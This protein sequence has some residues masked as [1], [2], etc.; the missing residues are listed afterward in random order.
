MLAAL[1]GFLLVRAPIVFN[2]Y[3]YADDFA[4]RWWAHTSALTPEYVFRSYYGHIQPFGLI[5]GWFM[6]SMFP[7]SF[8]ALMVCTLLAQL[9]TLALLWRIVLRLTG[10]NMAAF[11]AFLVPAFSMFGFETGIWWVEIAETVPYAFFLLVSVWALIRALEGAHG[12]WWLWSALAFGCALISISKGALGLIVLFMVASALPIGSPRRRGPRA[13]FGTAP[14]YWI[15]LL[16]AGMTWTLVLT[17]VAAPERDPNW[18]LTRALRYAVDMYL[19]NIA[20]AAVGGPWRWFSAP[21]ETW[22]GVLVIPLRTAPF[23]IIGALVIVAAFVVVRRYRPNLTAYLLWMCAYAAVITAL[24]AYARGGSAIASSGY[25]YTFDF[26]I[27]LALFA[28]LLFYPVVGEDDPFSARARSLGQRFAA[29][30]YGRQT[31]A[32]LAAAVF[33]ASCLASTVEPALRWVN[34]GTKQYVAAARAS[35]SAIPADAQFLPQKT[36]TDLVHP[37]LMLPYASTEVVFAP[38]PAFRPFAD[39]TTNGLFGF[40]ASGPAEQ[41]YVEGTSSK[42][43][44]VCGNKV[45]TQPITL[46]MTRPVPAWSFVTQVGYAA[47]ADTTMR[48]TVGGA[49]YDVPVQAGLHNVFFQVDG[50]VSSVTVVGTDPAATVCIDRIT[51]GSRLGP[52]NPTPVYPPPVLPPSQ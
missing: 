19:G 39:F 27:P 16:V 28:G 30:G 38:D 2:G 17:V 13:A 46:A 10:S 50:P 49:T 12:R 37:L 40:T 20:T 33:I 4:L 42:P 5:V 32:A 8:T 18:Q 43:R 35:M 23:L 34:S 14:L 7:G 1:A 3:L 15:V 29:K 45:T 25:R 22:N 44:G 31:V 11:L 6:Q 36:M 24:A 48:M 51:I 9:A 47:S 26:W 52:G 41:Q 21:G